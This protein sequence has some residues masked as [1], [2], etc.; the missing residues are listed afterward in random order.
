MLSYNQRLPPAHF[1]NCRM[2][3]SENPLY[4]VQF[5]IAVNRNQQAYR[6]L[7][8]QMHKP[9]IAFSA[10]I[11]HSQESSEEIFSDV[12]M[13]IWSMK[14]ALLNIGNLKVYLYK[15]IKNASLNYLAK[16]RRVSLIDIDNLPDNFTGSGTPDSRMLNQELAQKLS[17]AVSSL[18]PK[19]GLV[20]KLIKEE[21]LSY[22]QVSEILD[23]SVNT[24]EG[25]MTNALKKLSDSL[26]SYK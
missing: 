6:Q 9:L 16:M 18:P 11:T 2:T 10:T 21:N 23:I 19:C 26:R 13:K 5:E 8:L 4:G 24:I 12:F 17:A 22:K 15:S 1:A 20:F 25:H 7:Y 3:N 14:E